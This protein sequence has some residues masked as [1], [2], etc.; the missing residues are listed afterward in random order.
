MRELSTG[1]TCDMFVQSKNYISDDD[2]E[3]ENI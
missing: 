3:E 2:E 1:T